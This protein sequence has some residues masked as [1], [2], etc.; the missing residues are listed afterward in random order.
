M[1]ISWFRFE[2]GVSQHR[3]KTYIKFSDVSMQSDAQ[4]KI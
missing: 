2:K 3:D 1:I 4:D